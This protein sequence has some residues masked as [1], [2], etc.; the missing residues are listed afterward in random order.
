MENPDLLSL[1]IE[2]IER[3]LTP[4]IRPAIRIRNETQ[5]LKRKQ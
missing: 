5:K 4:K 3:C 1:Q 2:E